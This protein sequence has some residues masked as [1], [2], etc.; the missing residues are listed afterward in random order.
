[1]QETVSQNLAS[2]P[3]AGY[4]QLQFA[5]EGA[6]AG[7]FDKNKG[8]MP[9]A[10]LSTSFAHGDLTETGKPTDFAVQGDGFF[11]VKGADGALVYTRDGEF[12]I[13][14]ENT[15]VTKQGY[16]VMTE[17][18][19]VTLDPTKGQA[20]VSRDGTISQDGLSLGKL[21]LYNFSDTSKLERRDGDYFAAGKATPTAVAKP[22]IIQGYTEQGNSSSLREMVN[23]VTVSRAYEASQKLINTHDDLIH[24]AIQSL[25][26]S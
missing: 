24:Q 23:L 16:P 25:G 26:N 1:M 8:A 3:A 15:L 2:G 6:S 19:P 14:A 20:T 5:V 4:R 7:K 11:Q 21:P 10:T 18:G 17:S 22:A 9:K 13:N 12:Q